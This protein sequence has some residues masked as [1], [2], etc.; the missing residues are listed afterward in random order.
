MNKVQKD[1]G[2]NNQL[3]TTVSDLTKPKLSMNPCTVIHTEIF[4]ILLAFIFAKVG[5]QKNSHVKKFL[6]FR[7]KSKFPTCYY[8]CSPAQIFSS[9]S[10]KAKLK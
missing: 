4:I 6:D 5:K 8:H 7:K 1:N 9:C 10:R 3:H 2:R